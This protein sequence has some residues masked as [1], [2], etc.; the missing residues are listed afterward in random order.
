MQSVVF[1]LQKKKYNLYQ[2]SVIVLRG[3]FIC[4]CC[5]LCLQFSTAVQTSNL[6]FL[7]ISRTN[8]EWILSLYEEMKLIEV[9]GILVH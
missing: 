1:D 4:F 9:G 2:N 8:T 6:F 7:F 5:L 3:Y